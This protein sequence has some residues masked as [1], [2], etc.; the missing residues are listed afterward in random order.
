MFRLIFSPNLIQKA[1]QVG[2]WFVIFSLAVTATTAQ[3]KEGSFALKKRMLSNKFLSSGTHGLPS[4]LLNTHALLNSTKDGAPSGATF[5]SAPQHVSVAESKKDD[6]SISFQKQLPS[7][8]DCSHL[9]SL[10]CF[11][12]KD[13][14]P[15]NKL[16]HDSYW[17]VLRKSFH[18]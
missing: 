18:F 14:G 9:S 12:S 15:Y 4:Y 16:Q 7:N 13:E 1:M 8:N 5:G 17:L 6:W 10:L 3:S 11:D 2:F